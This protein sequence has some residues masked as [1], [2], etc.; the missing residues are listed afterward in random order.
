MTYHIIVFVAFLA[1]LF[2]KD[3][4]LSGHKTSRKKEYYLSYVDVATSAAWTVAIAFFLK[5]VWPENVVWND[6]VAILLMAAV[7]CLYVAVVRRTILRK[8][9]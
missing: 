4:Y 8:R 5:T 3:L 1:M 6:L 2:V 7:Y 9:N